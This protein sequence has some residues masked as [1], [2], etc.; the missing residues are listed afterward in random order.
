MPVPEFTPEELESE[1][2]RLI[3]GYEGVYSVSSLGRVRRNTQSPHK[4]A[5]GFKT[6][7]YM[8]KPSKKANG[9]PGVTLYRKG[10]TRSISV[11]TLVATAFIGP[12][13][14]G[15]EIEVNHKDL[16]KQNPRLS[17]L[18]YLTKRA[19][20]DHQWREGQQLNYGEACHKTTHDGDVVRA[21]RHD[22]ANGLTTKAISLKYATRYDYVWR[23]VT[24]RSRTRG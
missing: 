10:R 6:L 3:V 7:P 15:H 18:E 21:M 13:P 17:N 20:T 1:E 19:H 9:Y 22:F 5:R 12:K 14:P 2:W 11:H 23:V 16:N 8:L 24:N 4:R